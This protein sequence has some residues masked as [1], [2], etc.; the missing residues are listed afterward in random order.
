MY[1]TKVLA[2]VALAILFGGVSIG[3]QA[4]KKMSPPIFI[5]PP[6]TV[7][8]GDYTMNVNANEISAGNNDSIS[9]PTYGWTCSGTTDGDMSGFIFISMDY[10]SDITTPGEA[11][12][13]G[14]KSVI[15]GS[16]SKLIFVDGVYAGS[17]HGRL[18]GGQLVVN[19]IAGTTSMN[20]TLTVEDGDG[21]YAGSA[22]Y[23]TFEGVLAQNTRARSITGQLILN[24]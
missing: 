21:D 7:L 5:G 15:G 11:A 9:G 2:L 14:V 16:W 19:N 3:A 18:V 20:L 13:S 1:T 23:G 24:F 8:T 17:I 10:A 6:P 12:R 4:Q 22:G